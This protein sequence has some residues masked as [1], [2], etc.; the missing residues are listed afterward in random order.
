M[1]ETFLPHA[2]N[3]LSGALPGGGRWSWKPHRPTQ[4]Q[5]TTRGTRDL[6]KFQIN[7]TPKPMGIRRDH[8]LTLHSPLSDAALLFCSMPAHPH[9]GDPRHPSTPHPRT[10]D[11][12][13]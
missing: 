9:P 8:A 7:D 3:K 10:Y 2:C 5:P 11:G 4:P 13:F 1:T 6:G 12:D